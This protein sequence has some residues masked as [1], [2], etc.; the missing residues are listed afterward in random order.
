MVKKFF[1]ICLAIMLSVQGVASAK[2]ELPEERRI[3]IAVEVTDTSRHNDLGTAA[4]LELFL[5]GKLIDH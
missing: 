3:N 1:L 5:T 2:S 4:N